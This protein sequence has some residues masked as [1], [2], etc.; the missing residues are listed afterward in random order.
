MSLEVFLAQVTGVDFY[1]TKKVHH[2]Q[3]IWSSRAIMIQSPP[4]SDIVHLV[5]GLPP[6]PV[7]RP[8]RL[9]SPLFNEKRTGSNEDMTPLI[10]ATIMAVLILV[11]S[12]TVTGN[13]FLC[14]KSCPATAND[15]FSCWRGIPPSGSCTQLLP[16]QWKN[17]FPCPR[18]SS[19]RAYSVEKAGLLLTFFQT[20]TVQSTAC[21]RLAKP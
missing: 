13:D 6:P 14:A 7:L 12:L 19:A 8:S 17:V 4:H 2:S 21:I 16:P 9:L 1:I 5:P 18:G 20:T 15:F 3:K 10:I 11:I